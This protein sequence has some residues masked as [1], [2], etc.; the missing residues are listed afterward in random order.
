MPDTYTTRI[1][2]PGAFHRIVIS[3]PAQKEDPKKPTFYLT[4]TKDD[5]LNIHYSPLDSHGEVYYHGSL[6]ISD[7]ENIDACLSLVLS[8][9]QGEVTDMDT[10]AT[11]L[12]ALGLEKKVTKK[13][14]EPADIVKKNKKKKPEPTSA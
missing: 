8:V 5:K 13:D 1:D 11:D 10:F 7:T 12:A 4:P 3:D 6:D 9:M 14:A 2:T